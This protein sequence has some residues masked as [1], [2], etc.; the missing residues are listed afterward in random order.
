M[1]TEMDAT[2]GRM[3][4]AIQ[5]IKTKKHLDEELVELIEQVV[6]LQLK[7]RLEVRPPHPD[8]DAIAPPE[9]VALGKPLLPLHEFPFDA[10]RAES[11]FRAL[12]DLLEQH[13]G[14]LGQASQIIAEA[15][16]QGS[17]N[18]EETFARF[19]TGNTDYFKGWAEKFPEAPRTLDFLVQTSLTPSLETTAEI[20]AEHLPESATAPSGACPICGGLPFM[21]SIRGKKGQRFATCAMCRH[22]YRIRRM[23]CP[24]C[25]EDSETKLKYFTAKEEPGFRVETCESCGLYIKSVDFRTLDRHEIPALDDLDSLALDFVAHRE[26]YRR[27]TLSA[28]GF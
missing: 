8:Q 4:K 16:S 20:L 21:A 19:L 11:L 15:L 23:A 12:L 7:A 22:E 5:T 1:L 2:R 10:P 27:A 26:G 6:H 25:G 17:M 18:L 13:S 28:W 3:D 9:A 24:Y 14:P